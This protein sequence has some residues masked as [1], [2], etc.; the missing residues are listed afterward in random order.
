MYNS[1]SKFKEVPDET[2]VYCAHEYTTANARFALHVDPD[3]ADLQAYSK[4]IDRRREAGVSTAPSLMGVERRTNPFLRA[5]DPA[6][7]KVLGMEGNTPVEVFAAV[8]GQK[9]NF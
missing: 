7:A 9:D 5:D 6:F 2:W 8:R 3:N 1:I 4:Q